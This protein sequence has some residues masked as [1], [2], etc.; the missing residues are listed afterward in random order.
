M[1]TLAIQVSYQVATFYCQ[2]HPVPT[3]WVHILLLLSQQP[4]LFPHQE[5]YFLGKVI[6]LE[7]VDESTT[8]LYKVVVQISEGI[9]NVFVLLFDFF[10][11][12][13]TL[14]R[15]VEISEL[16]GWDLRKRESERRVVGVNVGK[17]LD[18]FEPL[19][20]ELFV[21]HKNELIPTFHLLVDLPE[22][23]D[24]ARKK[25]K[26]LKVQV[27]LICGFYPLRMGTIDKTRDHKTH[28]FIENFWGTLIDH[29]H[30]EN[31]ITIAFFC[32]NPVDHV[33]TA[34]S[35]YAIEFR[36]IGL[37]TDFLDRWQLWGFYWS[38][39][40]TSASVPDA[41]EGLEFLQDGG[42]VALPAMLPG[43]LPGVGMQAL[44]AP[45]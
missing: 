33:L 38:L 26:Y 25:V 3:H 4:H 32:L 7:H 37:F 5:I 43:D 39:L 42:S 19:K 11:H 40:N 44:S 24:V 6:F 28:G 27:D 10:L 31:H 14:K 45:G 1:S 20:V 15:R 41:F 8:F 21:G 13:E 29:S 2:G 22:L 16:G 23:F 12:S 30:L 35:F 18:Y 9:F 36:F 17:G 34:A